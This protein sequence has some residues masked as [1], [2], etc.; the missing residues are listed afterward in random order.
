MQQK[1]DITYDR[2]YFAVRLENF[3][4]ANYYLDAKADPELYNL[5]FSYE[6]M[7]DGFQALCSCA[8]PNRNI[9]LT[10]WIAKM[11]KRSL[12]KDKDSEAPGLGSEKFTYLN[13]I[14]ISLKLYKN[15]KSYLNFMEQIGL[16]GT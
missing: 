1:A 13:S 16:G 9:F 6:D 4:S 7:I 14:Q 12:R 11:V 3:W 8:H 15:K 5:L 10:Y 2:T